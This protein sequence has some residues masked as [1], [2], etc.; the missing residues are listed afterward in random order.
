MSA[1][2]SIALPVYN[3]ADTL[4]PAIESVLRQDHDDLELVI[5]DNAS[6]DGTE[7]V[8]RHYAAADP[9]VVYRRHAT[10]VGLLNNFRG[11]AESSRGR[12]VRWLGD[13]DSLEPDYVSRCL[14]VFAED[15][16][17]V[18]VTTQIAYTDADGGETAPVSYDPAALSSSDP[19]ER[20]AEMLR[21]MTAGF[22]LLDPLYA[23]MRREVAVMPRRNILREDEIFAARLALAG[24]WGH[25]PATL[26]RR[27]RSETDVPEL[28]R[29]LGV[30]SWHRHAMDLLQCR[31]LS[32]WIGRSDLDAAQRR[33]AHGEVLRLYGRRHRNRARRAVAKLE[34]AVGRPLDTSPS[35]AG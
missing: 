8:C 24:P 23:M 17:R 29:L 26:A 10:N 15:E 28:V 12:F 14:Q 2:V 33:R 21:L 27:S 5:S 20:F 25:V 3:G 32:H 4:A 31:E 22:A 30:P 11:A 9:R 16:R 6:T 13:D 19:V 1:S 35:R 18:L 7:E 34:R